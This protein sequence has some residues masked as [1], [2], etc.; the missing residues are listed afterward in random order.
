[1]DVYANANLKD[2]QSA[3]KNNFKMFSHVSGFYLLG[4]AILAIK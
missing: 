4:F 3:T 2:K 1:M